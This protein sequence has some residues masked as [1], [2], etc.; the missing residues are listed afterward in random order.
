MSEEITRWRVKDATIQAVQ[1]TGDAAAVQALTGRANFYAV[2]DQ[3]RLLSDDP[4]ATGA[5]LEGAHSSWTGVKPGAWIVKGVTGVLFAV[6]DEKFRET[7]EPAAASTAGDGWPQLAARLRTLDLA[8]VGR[9]AYAGYYAACGGKSL[10]SGQPIPDWDGQSAEIRRAWQSAGE[11][12]AGELHD[13]IRA[14]AGE[15][16]GGAR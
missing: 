12:V 15:L 11:F 14:Q 2:D 5:L 6:A 3:D 13:A 8:D 1:W 4:E 9:I 16:P 7:Y 10:V